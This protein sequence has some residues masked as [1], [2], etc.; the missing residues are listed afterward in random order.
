MGSLP[1][2]DETPDIPH[3]DCRLL[4]EQLGGGCHPPSH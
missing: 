2:A 3:R 4:D 1:V